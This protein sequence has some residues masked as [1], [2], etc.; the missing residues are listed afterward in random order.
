MKK[1]KDVLVTVKTRKLKYIGR[2]MST[3]KLDILLQSILH[4]KLY[5][6]ERGVATGG[7]SWSTNRCWRVVC[8]PTNMNPRN[9]QIKKKCFLI[10]LANSFLNLHVVIARC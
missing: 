6:K 8:N 5:L 9:I 7:I 3:G 4:G 1:Y 2:T 10:N